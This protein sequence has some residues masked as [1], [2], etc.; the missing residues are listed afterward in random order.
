MSWWAA[1]H[2][3]S[4]SHHSQTAYFLLVLLFSSLEPRTEPGAIGKGGW[5][6]WYLQLPLTGFFRDASVRVFGA[7]P[8]GTCSP[9][10]CLGPLSFS[11]TPGIFQD[12]VPAALTEVS[13]VT[14]VPVHGVVC[15]CMASEDQEWVKASGRCVRHISDDIHYLMASALC[16]EP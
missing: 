8:P 15:I 10:G 9:A 3:Y 5:T 11:A 12:S 2:G 13:S 16:S 4:C 1:L 6:L 7:D 14:R